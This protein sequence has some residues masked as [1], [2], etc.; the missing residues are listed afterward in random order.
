MRRDPYCSNCG[1]SLLGCTDSSKCPECGRPLVEVLTR[2]P[3]HPPGYSGVRRRSQ[4]LLFGLPLIDVAFGPHGDERFGHARGFIA[5][6]DKA[7][8]VIACGGK[9]IGVIAF[10]GLAIGVFAFGGLALGFIGIGGL[11]VGLILALG[12]QAVGAV[13]IGGGAL[14][15]AA[16]GGFAAGYGASGGM[17]FGHFAE[18]G[19]AVGTHVIT[20]MTRD[21]A[22]VSFF[23]TFAPIKSFFATATTS[24]WRLLIGAALLSIFSAAPALLTT[25]GMRWARKAD[26]VQAVEPPPPQRSA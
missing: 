12:G 4:Q 1:Y 24:V 3:L 17:A 16:F 2:D 20:A 10:G 15:L 8:G 18:G 23:Q 13:A 21:P 22:A 11:A 7:T 9:S 26:E 19:Q 14:G 5:L 6:G 25:L